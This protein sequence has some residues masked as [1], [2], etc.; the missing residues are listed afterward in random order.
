MEVKITLIIR[1]YFEIPAAVI[2]REVSANL[3]IVVL[4]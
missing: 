3:G 1:L 4:S 2:I